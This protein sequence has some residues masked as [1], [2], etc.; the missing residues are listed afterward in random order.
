MAKVVMGVLDVNLPQ[1][2]G[3]VREVFDLGDGYLVVVTTDRISAYDVVMQNGIP[4]KGQV[5][6][7]LSDFW[8]NQL[9]AV[10]QNH[11]I[12]TARRD[13]PPEFH[14]EEFHGRTMLCCK[15]TEVI[16]VECVVRGYITGSGWKSYTEDRTVCGIGL[17][18]GLRECEQLPVPIFTPTTKAE[19]GHDEAMDFAGVVDLIGPGHAG[20]LRDISIQ[21]YQE[22]A[23]YALERGIII[24]DTKFEFGFDASGELMLIDEVLT[25]DSSRFWPADV[26]KPGL[27]QP[28]FDKQPLRDWLQARCDDGEWDKTPPGPELP[29][30]VVG[31]TRA[32][33]A[34]AYEKL[35][36]QKFPF[37]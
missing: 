24:A 33:Y 1:K 5:L 35:T 12:S 10:V 16:P 22:A 29:D 7:L 3:K 36:G 9:G 20:M 18:A 8:F 15:A 13:M 25:P 27:V 14:G 11:M 31:Q 4:N 23:D 28:S 34:D 2:T 37:A 32:R 30:D 17:P 6:N 19:S 26:Y 21:L